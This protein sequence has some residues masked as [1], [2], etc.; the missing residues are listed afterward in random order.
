MQDKFNRSTLEKQRNLWLPLAIISGIILGAT[1]IGLISVLLAFVVSSIASAKG[2]SGPKWY[3]YGVWLWLIAIIH[4]ALMPKR[5]VIE[6]ASNS[7]ARRKKAK[8]VK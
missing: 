7:T 5:V 8:D 3:F 6:D 2:Y 4:I 1:V